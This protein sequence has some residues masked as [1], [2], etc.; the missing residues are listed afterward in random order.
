MEGPCGAG[1]CEGLWQHTPLHSTTAPS[2][3]QHNRIPAHCSASANQPADYWLSNSCWLFEVRGE[4]LDA[5]LETLRV[6]IAR[7]ARR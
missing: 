3:L 5:A 2:S 4:M 1:E 7:I 6:L